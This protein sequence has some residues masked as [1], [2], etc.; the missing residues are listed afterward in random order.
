MRQGDSCRTLS[1]LFRIAF[2][3]LRDVYSSG[4]IGQSLFHP[5]LFKCK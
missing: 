5:K 2:G 1:E 4:D 3:Q